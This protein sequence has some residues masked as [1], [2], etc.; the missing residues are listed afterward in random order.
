[1]P[2]SVLLARILSKALVEG[3]GDDWLKARAAAYAAC[4]L[5]DHVHLSQSVSVQ[6]HGVTGVWLCVLYLCAGVCSLW[7]VRVWFLSSLH[8]KQCY[9]PRLPWLGGAGRADTH[10]VWAVVCVVAFAVHTLWPCVG[11]LPSVRS[12]RGGY[13]LT[14]SACCMVGMPDRGFQNI[15]I[16]AGRVGLVWFVWL[17]DVLLCVRLVAR[18]A[19]GHR[20]PCLPAGW[21]RCPGRTLH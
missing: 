1:M 5:P 2:G 18:G 11:Q 14:V 21:W 19:G 20:L 13:E 4:S 17:T 15:R 7:S 12:E 16:A 6:C 10:V 8:N 9:Q 3:V